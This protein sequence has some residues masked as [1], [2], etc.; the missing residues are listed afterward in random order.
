[1]IGASATTDWEPSLQCEFLGSPG[2]L[3]RTQ[4]KP[5]RAATLVL[6]HRRLLLTRRL[7]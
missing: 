1:M 3:R 2:W 7:S 4:L 5:K 6:L